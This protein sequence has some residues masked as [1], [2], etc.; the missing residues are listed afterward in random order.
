[1]R[2]VSLLILSGVVSLHAQQ[3]TN[4]RT[5]AADIAAGAKTFRSHCSPCHGFNG[6]GARG[7]NLA[8]GRFYRGSTDADLLN[9]ISNGI[10]GT[11]MPGIF[12]S[13]DRVWQ[14]VA[15]VR[16]LS[17]GAAPAKGDPAR[18]RALYASNGCR[19]CHR[20]HGEGGRIGPDLSSIGQSRS[21]EHLRQAIVSPDADVRE[22]YWIVIARDKKGQPLEGFLLNEDTYTVQFLDTKEQLRS[23][24]KSDLAEYKVEKKSKM[25]SYK[26][27]LGE[28]QVDDLVA[29]LAT[30]RPAQGG[31]Q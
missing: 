6:E 7:P 22:R 16:S 20:L 29:Y 13:P 25:P 14:V 23:L 31:A 28:D 21:L 9:N 1:M 10:P 8:A 18:G 15:Y 12:Y 26:S 27:R 5:S 3:L 30:L 4:P 24:Q 2:T 19:N 11:E 17:A